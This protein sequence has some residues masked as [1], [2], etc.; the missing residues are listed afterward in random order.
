MNRLI[1]AKGTPEH[2]CH[3]ETMLQFV[4]P[5]AGQVAKLWRHWNPEVLVVHKAGADIASDGFV[6][7]DIAEFSFAL[8][9]GLAKLPVRRSA[10]AVADLTDVVHSASNR[11]G[12]EHVAESNPPEKV[13]MTPT[14][15]LRVPVAVGD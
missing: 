11:S 8:G 12:G 1:G 4:L 6:S 10:A 5:P 9:V 3:D 7:L 13:R 15:A 2:L 14:M